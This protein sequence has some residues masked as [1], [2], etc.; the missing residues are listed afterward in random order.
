MKPLAR[1]LFAAILLGCTACA[2]VKT[3]YPSPYDEAG[4]Q[5][6]ATGDRL[7]TK[8]CD[9][10]AVVH[11]FKA[12]EFFTLADNPDALA[13][14]FNNI[15]NL[16][17]NDGKN[18]EA[19]HYYREA[20]EIH[21]QYGNT[22][23]RIRLLT[24]MAMALI[25]EASPEKAEEALHSA[26]RLSTQAKI[27]WPRTLIVEAHLRLRHGD[28]SG[29]LAILGHIR[30]EREASETPL[31]AALHFARGKSLFALTR[32]D[33]ALIHFSHALTV[34]RHRG[35]GRLMIKDLTEMGRTLTAME[36]RDAALFHL[37]R[38]LG[39]ATLLDAEEE[40]RKLQAMVIAL[41]GHTSD[42]VTPISD[43]FLERWRGEHRLTAPCN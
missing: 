37:Q 10:G 9:K 17:L 30:G 7:T 1:L 4:A 5:A 14:C 18:R 40:Q 27:P 29:A 34:D 2:S 28:A 15:G 12:V 20:Y 22:R 16:Y 24:N 23:G 6:L 42:S 31:A 11:Y 21:T 8:G 3:P 25:P 32:Y 13:T 43:Y 38:A 35:A 26:Q 33:E 39:I 19:L 36:K 41:S